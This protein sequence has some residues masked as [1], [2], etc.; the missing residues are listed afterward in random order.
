MEANRPRPQLS[1]PQL[2]LLNEDGQEQEILESE[3]I[4]GMSTFLFFFDFVR[5]NVSVFVTPIAL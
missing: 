5:G 4:L 2:S 3:D 1:L